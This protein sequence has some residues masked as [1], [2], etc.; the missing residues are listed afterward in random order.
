MLTEGCLFCTEQQL[1]PAST[2]PLRKY[3]LFNTEIFQP[4]IVY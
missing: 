4:I 3:T 2:M 1:N